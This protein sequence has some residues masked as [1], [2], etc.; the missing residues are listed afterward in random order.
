MKSRLIAS[1]AVGAAVILGASGCAMLSPQGTTIPY[2]PSDGINVP[3]AP[4]A[5]LQIRNAMI[6]ATANGADGNLVA[7]IVNQT[8]QDA[9]LHVAVT[10]TSI[11]EQIDVPAN[12]TVSLGDGAQNTDPLLLSGIDTKPG[13][14]LSV[15][16]QSGEAD[17]VPIHL[18][19]LDGTLPYYATLVP[20]PSPT[21]LHGVTLSPTPTPSTT[22]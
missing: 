10:G 3:D 16:F 6:I 17:G 18:P 8:D 13:K 4:N 19:V 9:T 2:S 5:P 11:S 22:P 1:I 20:T 7:A 15:V 14:T 21:I 12:S